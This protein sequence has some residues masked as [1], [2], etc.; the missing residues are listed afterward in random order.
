[1]ADTITCFYKST[2]NSAGTFDFSITSGSEIPIPSYIQDGYNMAAGGTGGRYANNLSYAGPIAPSGI[3]YFRKVSETL[4]IADRIVQSG[5]SFS[6]LK[7]G[8]Y[9]AGF[10]PNG[11]RILSRS[12][13]EK[14]ITKDWGLWHNRQSYANYY[15]ESFAEL[16][17]TVNSS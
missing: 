4:Y 14:Y 11:I 9:D 10:N 5:I 13:Y 7:A 17:S 8:S 16:T 6:Q 3:F 1:M 2:K 15:S 12:E